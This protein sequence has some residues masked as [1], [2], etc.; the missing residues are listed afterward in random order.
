MLISIAALFASDIFYISNWV[1]S[2]ILL[3]VNYLYVNSNGVNY[4]SLSLIVYTV[5]ILIS[6]I[7]GYKRAKEIKKEEKE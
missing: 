5:M 1:Y 3:Y 7:I 2:V 6:S 4:K